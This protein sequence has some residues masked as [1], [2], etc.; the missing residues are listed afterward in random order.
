ML[1]LIF[2]G[3]IRKMLVDL[4]KMRKIMVD[5][6]RFFE[7]SVEIFAPNTD[8]QTAVCEEKIARK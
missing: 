1:P 2:S 6:L 3:K 5:F 4:L 8:W 7:K